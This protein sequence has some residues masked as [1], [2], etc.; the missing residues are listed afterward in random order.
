V[1]NR[2]QSAKLA[3]LLSVELGTVRTLVAANV[4]RDRGFR[5]IGECLGTLVVLFSIAPA[6][7]PVLCFSVVS[8]AAVTATF[9]RKN[10]RLFAMDAAAQGAV[11]AAASATLGAVRTVRSF[12]GESLSFAKFGEDV[13]KVRLFFVLVRAILMSNSCF[14]YRLGRLGWRWLARGLTWRWLTAGACTP[15]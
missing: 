13:G 3:A 5:A 7:A 10:G 14:V 15:R 6:L 11:S 9:N 2:N 8:L 1:N 4:S 12:G